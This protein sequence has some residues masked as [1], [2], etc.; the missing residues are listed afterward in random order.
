M[1]SSTATQWAASKLGKTVTRTAQEEDSPEARELA[2]RRRM[3]S[4]ADHL[5]LRANLE[6]RKTGLRPIAPAASTANQRPGAIN[7]RTNHQPNVVRNAMRPRVSQK[8]SQVKSTTSGARIPSDAIPASSIS[9]G[10]EEEG[11]DDDE[12]EEQDDKSETK[13][14]TND[15][16]T[17]NRPSTNAQK[18]WAALR[19]GQQIVKVRTAFNQIAEDQKMFGVDI[20]ENDNTDDKVWHS[21]IYL[22]GHGKRWFIIMP[23]NQYRVGWDVFEA[24][25]LLFIAFYIPFRLAFVNELDETWMVVENMV[26]LSFVLSICINFVTAYYTPEGVLVFDCIKVA[27]NYAKGFFMIDLIATIPFDEL[28]EGDDDEASSALLMGRLARLTRVL[29]FFRIARLFR[30][31]KV[32][33]LNELILK[34]ESNFNI[35]QVS[36]PP[37]PAPPSPAPAR[38]PSA[39]TAVRDLI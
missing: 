1:N 13:D 8:T 27:K 37:N 17:S 11:E 24:L 14:S 7:N 2:Q 10:F 9:E 23:D 19:K 28:S 35:H 15:I 36:S 26:T 29:K 21:R 12:A 22:K 25:M 4:S 20:K 39:R 32:G 3:E 6:R 16:V 31:L 38:R 30:L 34:M 5:P 33:R 18:N